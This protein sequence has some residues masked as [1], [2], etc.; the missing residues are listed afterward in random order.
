M[1]V[2]TQV[3]PPPYIRSTIEKT[4]KFVSKHGLEFETRIIACNVKSSIFKFLSTS[5]PYHAFY[6][7]KL[8]E[9][10][11][12]NQNESE[13][14]N[15]NDEDEEYTV[16]LPEGIT[17]QELDTIKFTVQVVARNG[18][19]FL[20]ELT[21]REIDNSEHHF[22]FK[23]G[24]RSIFSFVD[25]LVA[26]QGEH[27]ESR[28]NDPD[29]VYSFE[30][31]P[32]VGRFNRFGTE[33]SAMVSALTQVVS[34]RS[35]TSYSVESTHSS[36]S[37]V[38]H[39]RERLG[40][41]STIPLSTSSFDRVD[42]SLGP[43]EESTSKV[44]PEEA[45]E[46]RR[47]YRGVRQRPWGKWAAEIRDPHKAA[48]VWLGTFNTAEAAARAYDEAALR[49]R[50]SKAKLNFPEDARILPPPPSL[51]LPSAE[52]VADEGGE[53]LRD[54][55]STYPELLQS[56]G[57]R[58]LFGEGQEKSTNVL[59]RSPESGPRYTDVSRSSPA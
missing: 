19:S 6:Q 11:A 3:L 17:D 40:I 35:L 13:A 24:I 30:D 37:S 32:V 43:I 33:M 7:H 51:L 49:F 41:R 15:F 9:Y 53:D 14:T 23:K 21:R 29:G 58:S 42:S 25:A 12:Q 16:I 22:H 8:S 38:G 48:R 28:A 26:N 20:V 50:G 44:L 55:G 18:R 27:T 34:A 56:S 10:R 54:Y 46:K 5:D 36:S 1:F 47:R 52:A 57:Q 31:D 4:A 39:T 45:R 59:E 2:S